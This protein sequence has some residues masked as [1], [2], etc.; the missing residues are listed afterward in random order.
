MA[1]DRLRAV[2]RQ[3]LAKELQRAEL[4]ARITDADV[5]RI[6]QLVLDRLVERLFPA[7]AEPGAD[8]KP[9]PPARGGRTKPYFRGSGSS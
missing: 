9:R 4:V 8:H 5:E 7:L 1:E 3:E 6:A 2:V